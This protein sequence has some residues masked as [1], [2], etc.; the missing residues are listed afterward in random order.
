[1]RQYLIL[2][3]SLLLFCAC[4]DEKPKFEPDGL[5]AYCKCYTENVYLV[6]DGVKL[7]VADA[8]KYIPG[9]DTK[10]M[11]IYYVKG[12]QIRMNPETDFIKND[13]IF[14][15]DTLGNANS[16]DIL[17]IRVALPAKY[18][19]F[20]N[21]VE[22]RNFDRFGSAFYH[23]VSKLCS[24]VGF[25]VF[26]F[27]FNAENVGNEKARSYMWISFGL[28]AV[29][30]CIWLYVL[31][32]ESCPD[33]LF[34]SWAALYGACGYYQLLYFIG[35]NGSLFS[36][37]FCE[38]LFCTPYLLYILVHIVMITSLL[39]NFNNRYASE[40]SVH[41]SIGIAG[42]FM[43][44]L[45]VAASTLFNDF[46]GWGVVNVAFGLGCW[47]A[48]DALY[49]AFKNRSILLPFLAVLI[50]LLL[51]LTLSS[52]LWIAISS[53]WAFIS[54]AFLGGLLFS[55]LGG[56]TPSMVY[57]NCGECSKWSSL[58]G[59]DRGYCSSKREPRNRYTTM[60]HS[61]REH[62]L[63]NARNRNAANYLD[64]QRNPRAGDRLASGADSFIEIVID[65]I[66][67]VQSTF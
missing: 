45:L 50:V 51:I 59:D 22:K 15:N 8:H 53:F 1:M 17:P 67:R 42:L 4:D 57:T 30:L 63:E 27:F 60:C 36:D 26:D 61:V 16:R 9:S 12:K 5:T 28:L 65:A 25:D 40:R 41:F 64:H 2:L 39:G 49:A 32:A 20:Q 18:F 56:Y 52:V 31:F 62:V 33:L 38:T 14:M 3:L 21:R 47:L 24:Y 44:V 10:L 35:Y 37:T 43:Y 48:L 19:D 6:E 34:W 29:C 46:F 55:L 7:K 54:F 66:Y 58:H 13:T 11:Y 23:R